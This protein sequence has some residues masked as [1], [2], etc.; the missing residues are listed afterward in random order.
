MGRYAGI[1]AAARSALAL[2]MVMF[3]GI[4]KIPRQASMI[5]LSP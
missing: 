1:G 2:D 4:G 3:G 5:A